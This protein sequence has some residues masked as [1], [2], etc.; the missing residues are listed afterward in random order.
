MSLPL[1][2]ARRPL[3]NERLPTLLFSLACALLGALTVQHGIVAWELRGGGARDVAGRVL[4]LE[5]EIERLSQ[6]A[7]ALGSNAP[8]RPQ[9]DE[10]M[11]IKDLVD[12]RV[13][14]WTGLFAALESVLPP[15]VRLV[16]VAP[17][18]GSRGSGTE[19]TLAALGRSYEDAVALLRALQSDQRFREARL[20]TFADQE[21]GVAIGCTVRYIG[22]PARGDR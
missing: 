21:G 11:T 9:L 1:N 10:W 4:G 12:H 7:A 16:S 14:S 15:S 13:F 19:L 8:A 5:N 6:E 18:L 3:R 2:L 22:P 17:S 20:T